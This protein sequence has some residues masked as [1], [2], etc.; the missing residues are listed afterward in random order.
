MKKILFLLLLP[1]LSYG[2]QADSETKVLQEAGYKFL[3]KH[4]VSS[5]KNEEIF[6]FI[7][8]AKVSYLLMINDC[9]VVVT[10]LDE[11]KKIIASNYVTQEKK[12]V[13]AIR[14]NIQKAGLYYIKYQRKAG[15]NNTSFISTIAF[16][17]QTSSSLMADNP[18][19]VDKKL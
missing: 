14:L 6:T 2:Q 9:N 1:F 19:V 17:T 7:F 4:I 13:S 10:I 5:E 8:N 18:L 11:D 12:C 16:K 15:A 3:K